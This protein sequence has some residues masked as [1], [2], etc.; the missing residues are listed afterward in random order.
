MR[1]TVVIYI[2]LVGDGLWSLEHSIFKDRVAAVRFNSG[3]LLKW[4][5]PIYQDLVLF[6]GRQ[7]E[8]EALIILGDSKSFNVIVAVATSYP[9]NT[10]SFA[11]GLMENSVA[12]VRNSHK[13]LRK[14]FL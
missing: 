11:L 5:K 12:F 10:H 13:L 9:L 2:A 3:S 7:E 8:L 14:T 1:F 6:Y 4:L